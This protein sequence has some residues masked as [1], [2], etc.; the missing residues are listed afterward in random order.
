MKHW[1]DVPLG[2]LVICHTAFLIRTCVSFLLFG[3]AEQLIEVSH[4]L[5][6]V[7]CQRRGGKRGIHVISIFI[8]M[9][10]FKPTHLVTTNRK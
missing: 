7:A 3:M 1:G 6:K 10:F 9:I 5:I 2:L 4:L 8:L